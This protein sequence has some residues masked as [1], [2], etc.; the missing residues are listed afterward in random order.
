MPFIHFQEKK[1]KSYFLI[2]TNYFSDLTPLSKLQ[3]IKAD[4]FSDILS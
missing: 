1:V 2:F 3:Q 4:E